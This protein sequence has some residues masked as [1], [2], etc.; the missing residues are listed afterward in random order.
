MASLGRGSKATIELLTGSDRIPTQF[1]TPLLQMIAGTSPHVSQCASS[2]PI[3]TKIS[4]GSIP[5]HRG[6]NHT[7]RQARQLHTSS[8]LTALFR[9]TSPHPPHT[10]IH[11]VRNSITIQFNGVPGGSIV[12]HL[13]NDGTI[14]TSS[15][16]HQELNQRREQDQRLAAEENK[17]P[18]L[19]QTDN[20]RQAH[21]RMEARIR[22]LRED[23]R[24]SIMNKLLEKQNAQHEY[25]EILRQQEQQR[26]AALKAAAKKH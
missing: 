2:S 15:E 12:A 8:K 10:D 17:F 23:R 21:A 19:G 5:I 20:R 25:R 16:M 6:Q 26:A 9:G 1:R 11:E 3:R 4:A 7:V 18:A 13:F 22:A 24:M 14:K